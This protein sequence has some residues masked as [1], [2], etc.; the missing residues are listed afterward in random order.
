MKIQITITQL[1]NLLDVA[2]ES[3]KRDSSLSNTIQMTLLAEN[4]TH[5]GADKLRFDL[6]SSYAESNGQY[7]GTN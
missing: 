7:L 4:Q 6:K 1:E 2:R 3:Q 5:C